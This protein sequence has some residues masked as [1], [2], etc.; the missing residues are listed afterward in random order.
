MT[1]KGLTSELGLV[2]NEFGD[3]LD[4]NDPY[5]F[6]APM[7]GLGGLKLGDE[8]SYTLVMAP[9]HITQTHNVQKSSDDCFVQIF[10]LESRKMKQVLIDATATLP[11]S[12]DSIQVASFFKVETYNRKESHSM[13]LAETHYD[14]LWEVEI[15]PRDLKRR[16]MDSEATKGDLD[17]KDEA[18]GRAFL[19]K[20]GH[21]FVSKELYGGAVTRCYTESQGTSVSQTSVQASG[22]ERF[23]AVWQAFGFGAK[24]EYEKDVKK[25]Q[26]NELKKCETFVDGGDIAQI[27]DGDVTE[28]RAEIQKHRK[29]ARL[30]YFVSPTMDIF[31][32]GSPE[33]VILSDIYQ[34]D[35]EEKLRVNHN[36]MVEEILTRVQA[37]GPPINV[38]V[39][40]AK[41]AG[42]SSL[43]NL[44]YNSLN[45]SNKYI[46]KCE[47][48]ANLEQTITKSLNRVDVAPKLRLFDF[49]GLDPSKVKSFLFLPIFL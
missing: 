25:T 16:L 8:N 9:A 46:V 36:W 18:K 33:Y 35:Q 34:K 42:K 22:A 40:G 7:R 3:P 41:G 48:A 44:I 37:R 5:N 47:P 19:S 2:F 12:G 6:R 15:N 23:S 43:I 13:V 38:L 39:I 24:A 11:V 17:I 45:F 32:R 14:K 49:F 29:L 1:D 26:M 28:W 31:A 21:Y 20:Y 27:K 30:S 10:T 4:A